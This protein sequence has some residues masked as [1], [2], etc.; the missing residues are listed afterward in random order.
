MGSVSEGPVKLASA[1]VFGVLFLLSWVLYA[2][3][4][5]PDADRICLRRPPGRH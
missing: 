5:K 3:W 2:P 1:I 4:R